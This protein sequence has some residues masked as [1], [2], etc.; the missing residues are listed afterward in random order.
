M[1]HPLLAR[2]GLYAITNGPRDDLIE[3]CAAAIDGGAV[4]L[5][6]RDKTA[7]TH[8]RLREARALADLCAHS[9]IAFIVNDDIGLAMSVDAAGV[10]LGEDDASIADA[11][12]RL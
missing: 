12:A 4:L 2:D 9:G 7:D 10:H 6:Y 1:I 8:R 11:R 3:A 5:Q